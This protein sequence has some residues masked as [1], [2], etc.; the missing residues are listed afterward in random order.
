MLIIMSTPGI[1][2]RKVVGHPGCFVQEDVW[3][4]LG[5]LTDSG[6]GLGRA[7]FIPDFAS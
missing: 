4:L 3:S 2:D 5:S 1:S 7:G 6:D